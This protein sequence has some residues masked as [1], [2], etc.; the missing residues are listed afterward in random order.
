MRLVPQFY[1]LNPFQRREYKVFIEGLRKANPPII[2]EPG[3]SAF[4]KEVFGNLAEILAHH[5]RMLAALFIRQS[6]QHPLIQS[7]A[8]IILDSKL[9]A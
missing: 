5:K 6:S 1:Q 8:D 4:I 7:I 2:T 3:L 9:T